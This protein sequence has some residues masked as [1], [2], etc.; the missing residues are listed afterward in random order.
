MTNVKRVIL[1]DKEIVQFPVFGMP[2][3]GVSLTESEIDIRIEKLLNELDDPSHPWNTTPPTSS[4]APK[5][6]EIR[7][8]FAGAAFDHAEHADVAL[9]AGDLAQAELSYWRAQAAV[10]SLFLLRNATE[11]VK[12]LLVQH[13]G[14]ARLAADKK[15]RTDRIARI[16]AALIAAGSPRRGLAKRIHLEWKG[17]GWKRAD[18]RAP[19][20]RTIN[21]HL[22]ATGL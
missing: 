5:F 21:E 1:S 2:H 6:D 4:G 18:G 17:H 12:R 3:P 15:R 14:G 9:E 10:Q 22:A 19:S 16:A 13:R 20:E 8:S 11:E 7:D